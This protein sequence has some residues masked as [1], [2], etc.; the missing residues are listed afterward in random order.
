MFYHIFPEKILLVLIKIER[1]RSGATQKQI[2]VAGHNFQYLEAGK[3][4]PLVLV[5]GFSG[6]KDNWTRMLPH[7]TKQYR[8]IV[9]DVPGF[10]ENDRHE[11][12]S[13]DMISQL[14]RLKAFTDHMG[15]KSFSIAGN[16]QGGMLAMMFAYFHPERIEKMVLVN[17]AGITAP[18]KNEYMKLI[19]DGQVPLASDNAE[20]FERAW[21]MVFE[22]RPYIP[23]LLKD[24]FQARAIKYSGFTRKIWDDQQKNP[25]TLDEILSKISKDIETLVIWGDKDKILDVSCVDVIRQEM[26]AAKVEILKDCGHCPQI[27]MPKEVARSIEEFIG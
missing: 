22:K 13:Y 18:V 26:P 2:Y 6:D 20:Q 10:G 17:A 23:K 1:S 8:V 19:D 5:H 9:P 14:R 12:E 24:Y 11:D 27:E 3:E 15:L 25:F 16:S 4:K 7:F 21:D